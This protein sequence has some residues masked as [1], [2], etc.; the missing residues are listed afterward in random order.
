MY[1]H[2]SISGHRVQCDA[3]C[4]DASLL[5]IE[6]T[7][8]REKDLTKWFRLSAPFLVSSFCSTICTFPDGDSTTIMEKR[9]AHAAKI[10]SCILRT[11][12]CTSLLMKNFLSW[13][14]SKFHFSVNFSKFRPIGSTS[15]D[16]NRVAL[17]LIDQNC[18]NSIQFRNSVSIY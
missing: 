4:L 18:K 12:T 16:N 10:S 15:A 13:R 8:Q 14:Y 2:G 7:H 11:I 1:W 6:Q 3:R 17:K 5:K 9:D